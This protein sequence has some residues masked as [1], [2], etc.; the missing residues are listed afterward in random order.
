MDIRVHI[1]IESSIENLDLSGLPEGD[2]EKSRSFATGYYSYSEE[3]IALSYTEENEG[4]KA[5]SEI[6]ICDGGVRVKRMGAIES[7]LYFKEG[8]S[9][10]SIYSVPPYKF[11]ATVKTRRIR[12]ELDENGGKIDL[13]YNMKIGGAEKSARMKIW[14]SKALNQV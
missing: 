9:H 8:E 13:F 4:G 14:I 6:L 1:K 10:S 5:D 2:V 12:C 3:K 11:D 7:D